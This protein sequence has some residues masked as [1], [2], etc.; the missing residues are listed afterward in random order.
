MFKGYILTKG[1]KPME[2]LKN[3][4]LKE[5]ETVQ[6][7]ESYGGILKDNVIMIDVDELE[8]ANIINNILMDLGVKC[9]KLHTTRG[10]HFY[11]ERPRI[12]ERNKIHSQTAVG[13]VCDVK[14]GCKL[15]C[16]PLKIDGITRRFE[17][18]DETID[19]L[20]SWLFP[21]DCDVD[22]S[23]IGDGGGRNQ[24]LFNYI[25]TL[26]RVGMNKDQIKHTINI[27]NNYVLLDPLD[28]SE[29]D[30]ILR[31]ESFITESFNI[32]GK[33]DHNGFANYIMSDHNVINIDGQLHIFNGQFYTNDIT[34][35]E[36]RILQAI[37]TLKRNQR[38]EVLE[39]IRINAPQRDVMD[40]RY[41]CVKNGI[42]NIYTR[43]LLDFTPDMIFTSQIATNYNP[44][45]YS[46]DL[47]N[48]LNKVACNDQMIKTQ[49]EE[50]V[51]CCIA[52]HPLGMCFIL[53]GDGS[54]GKSTI[55]DCMKSMLGKR[56]YSSLDFKDL[57]HQFRASALYGK[58]ANI[59]DDIGS[60]YI[61]DS[62]MFKKIATG[63]TVT[64]EK[65]GRDA[66]ETE[67]HS[68]LIY[69]CNEIP[70]IN[71]KTNGLL[72]R[73]MLISFDAEF[74]INDKDYDPNIKDKLMSADSLEYLLKLAVDRLLILENTSR[75]FTMSKRSAELKSEYNA[76]IN[77]L[78]AW[79][80]DVGGVD[81]INCKDT[82]TVYLNYNAWCRDNG[83]IAESK[84][85]LSRA[86][87]RYK[88]TT[89]VSKIDGK[90]LKIYTLEG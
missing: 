57:N 75:R 26:Q 10:I 24:A 89:K 14:V 40:K 15:T 45:A 35:I 87:K 39:L 25:L 64:L 84:T 48:V 30:V 71:D 59:G 68:T 62:S 69:A 8:S 70:K 72:R 36:R 49:I 20:P 12:L 56:N 22:F 32:N 46:E 37:P 55:L 6:N 42:L 13:I 18:C 63:E 67:L 23:N 33:F 4:Q 73:L 90:S 50:M 3:A 82:K 44:D 41:I 85:K 80:D 27:I 19:I 66:F 78:I 21:I 31:D 83:F 86:L 9:H 79:L 60:G 1:K 77:P 81:W 51:A 34:E 38:A 61:D 5:L 58:L 65:K 76:I 54:N 17:L 16:V 52:R 11:F 7:F 47:A 43:Q 29:I 28:Q 53:T 2:S 74:S 88:I